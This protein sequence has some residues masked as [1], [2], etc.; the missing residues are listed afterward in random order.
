MAFGI[1]GSGAPGQAISVNPRQPPISTELQDMRASARM[2]EHRLS[3]YSCFRLFLFQ[4]IPG[5]VLS[6]GLS[7]IPPKSV[8]LR[9]SVLISAVLKTHCQPH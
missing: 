5:A 2:M 1:S 3:G 4:A 7:D 6:A 9:Q 8:R